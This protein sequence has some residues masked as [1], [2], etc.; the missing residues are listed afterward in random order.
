MSSALCSSALL[1]VG[2]AFIYAVWWRR[3]N[4]KQGALDFWGEPKR[5]TLK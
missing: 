5:R 2:L 1:I 4:K 3:Q